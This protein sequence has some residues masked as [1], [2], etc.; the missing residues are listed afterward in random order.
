MCSGR[1]SLVVCCTPRG[2]A[3]SVLLESAAHRLIMHDVGC[4]G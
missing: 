1:Q 3:D 2:A 4:N